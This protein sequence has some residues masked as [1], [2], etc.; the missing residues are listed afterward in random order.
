VPQ[1]REREHARRESRVTG[2]ESMP[3]R[4]ERRC[5]RRESRITGRKRRLLRRE[6]E[7]AMGESRL[8][9]RESAF[10]LPGLLQCLCGSSSTRSSRES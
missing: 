9:R 8:Q 1:R 2:R 10:L 6:R 5:A 7:H 4:R 3:Q